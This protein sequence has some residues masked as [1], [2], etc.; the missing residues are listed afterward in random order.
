VVGE[1]GAGVGLEEIEPVDRQKFSQNSRSL[2]WSRT[3]PPSEAS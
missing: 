1:L 2:A 3:W